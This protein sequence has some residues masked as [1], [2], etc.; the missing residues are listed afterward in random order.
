MKGTR[1]T[2]WLCTLLL[3]LSLTH[4]TANAQC[5]LDDWIALKAL[6]ESTDGDN[7]TDNTNWQEVTGNQPTGNCNLGN[8]FG[9]Q[10][11]ENGRVS[12]LD[13]DGVDDCLINY[14]N[15]GN[16]LNGSI[17]PE[18][19]R[20]SGLTHLLLQKNELSGSIP[21]EM[22]ELS[23]LTNLYLSD[24]QLTGSI[25]PELGELSNLAALRLNF[26]K[27]SG[28]IPPELGKLTNL[29]SLYLSGNE[30]SG[31]IPPELGELI[32]LKGMW[33]NQNKLSGSIPPALGKLNKLIW[34]M[35]YMN[36]LSGSI[37]PELGDLS[38]LHELGLFRNQL[39]GSIPPE[40]STLSKLTKLTLYANQLN[41]SIP[42]ELGNL[43]NLDWLEIN[44]NNLSGCYDANL[45]KLCTQ[46]SNPDFKGNADISDG[47][48]FDAT[49][50]DFCAK[51]VDACIPPVTNCHID[52]WT[53]LKALYE[54][55]DGINW[56]N[57]TN[58][59]EVTGNQ[60]TNNCNLE[61]LYGVRLDEN[62]RVSCLDFDGVDDCIIDYGDGG[63]NLNGSIPPEVGRLSNLTRLLLHNNNLSGNIPFELG[64]LSNLILLNLSRNKLNGSI[65]VELEKLSNLTL[66]H[67]FTNQLSDN[68]PPELGNLSNLTS[69]W[70][71][72]NQLS[73]NIPPTLSRLNKLEY[74]VL[75]NNQ[76]IGD[77]PYELGELSNLLAL[78]LSGNQLSGS[79]PP[80]LS[81][82]SKLISLLLAFNELNGT[83]PVELA[84]LTELK[85]LELHVNQLSGN[86]PIELTNLSNLE[87]LS[88]S[89]NQLSGSIPPALSKLSNLQY[90]GLRENEFSGS[91]PPELGNLSNLQYLGLS[92]N[93]IIGNMPTELSN[94]INL[95]WLEINNNNLSGCYDA[96]L[97]ILCTQLN[98]TNFKGNADISDGNNFDATWEDFCTTDAGVCIPPI[99]N[100][101]ID[102]WT[103]LKALY[104]STNGINWTNNTNWQEVT[105]NQPTNNCNLETLYGV[106][107]DENG[108]VSCLDFDGVDDCIIDYG[109]GGNNLNGSIP[110]EVGRLNNLTRLLLQNN[111]LSGSIPPELGNLSN[112][113]WLILAINELNGSIPA[114]LGNLN[115]LT[116]LHIFTNQLSGR[117]PPELGNL[118]NLSSLWLADNQLIGEIPTELGEL[119]NLLALGFSGNQFSGNIPTELG[120]LS[121]LEFLSA[122]HNNLSGCYDAD[123][124][125][126]CTQLNNPDFE[127][128]EDISD[129][130]NFDATWEDFCA[131]GVDACIKY[132]HIDDWTALKAIYL[133]TNNAANWTNRDNWDIFKNENP[134]QDCNLSGLHG[135]SF[136]DEGRVDSINLS[137]NNL[138]GNLSDELGEANFSVIDISHNYFSF[139]EVA[140][141]KPTNKFKYSPQYFGEIE[142]YNQTERDTVTIST[143]YPYLNQLS[144]P[145]YKWKKDGILI[146]EIDTIFSIDDAMQND[147]GAYRLHI[148]ESN[149]DIELELISE[150]IHLL[151]KGFDPIGAPVKPNEFLYDFDNQEA[152][153]AFKEEYEQITFVDSCHCDSRL[154]YLIRHESDSIAAT[155]MLDILQKT[156]TIVDTT[157]IE[158]S[159]HI[160]E[161]G[162][163]TDRGPV[164]KYRYPPLPN[165]QNSVSI[166]LLDTGFDFGMTI[167][168]A[169]FGTPNNQLCPAISQQDFVTKIDDING[170][171]SNGFRFITDGLD[172]SSQIKVTPLRV[173]E[174]RQTSLFK[175]ICALYYSIDQGADIINLS[176]GYSGLRS[177]ILEDALSYA[178]EKG[179]FIVT[180]AGNDGV[181]IDLK[182]HYPATFSGGYKNVISIG[183]IN[184]NNRLTEFTNYGD[185]A[186]TLVAQGK[187]MIGFGMDD[188]DIIGNGTSY[189]TYFVARMLA[190][191]IAEDNTLSSEEVWS[192][193]DTKYLIDNPETIG[194]CSTG[195][196]LDIEVIEI[197]DSTC[198]TPQTIE[199]NSIEA[200]KASIAW[201]DF[202][203]SISYTLK[204][205]EKDSLYWELEMEE[206]NTNKY[207]LT[208]L[209][210]CTT[211]EVIVQS[212]CMHN[213][214]SGYSQIQSF[215]TKNCTHSPPPSPPLCP[216][217][218]YIAANKVQSKSA[219]IEWHKYSKCG[220]TGYNFEYRK[221]GG[222]WICKET[223]G[224]VYQLNNLEKC[225]TYQARVNMICA[226]EKSGYS[227][228]IE[229]T[230]LD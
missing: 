109:S 209:K 103:A 23:N 82:L 32:N 3:M 148:T 16:N 92:K 228:T 214:N 143:S 50:E 162:V 130:N 187:N 115:N 218:V 83:I 189:S 200:N 139:Q 182:P 120:N 150:P 66:L 80:E 123:L 195:K 106:R 85:N 202:S 2:I 225:T 208:N 14:G 155:V 112:L 146:N 117:I 216:T 58:W 56:T 105:G 210:D 151:V 177:K 178:Q 84:D 89:I 65:P 27:L 203:S 26:N 207:E 219:E 107:L 124:A 229:F 175:L 136:D 52:D 20:L 40:L 129:G 213:T 30:L 95:D 180:A 38:N 87:K 174:D 100:C 171:G 68:I 137:R 221:V 127:G 161:S 145:T 188:K 98:N 86:I 114:E 134:P 33:L 128:N 5:H 164:F 74:L 36:E 169:H 17:P 78:G 198:F 9:V 110:P 54:S 125:K 10:L 152:L 138:S 160:V 12:C 183:S 172:A 154:L 190:L 147:V 144:E 75:H 44:H 24:N 194:M 73:G 7:W 118:S 18:L 230:T 163:I 193:F 4:L 91:I 1:T 70:L 158:D 57:N 133:S 166:Y 205:R 69:L 11:D 77:I 53:A 192:K 97:T 49:W 185:T 39:S 93:K 131:K 37:P 179:I 159:N 22:G 220:Q 55:T 48:N 215:T 181:D 211:Y 184:H 99:T 199:I 81:K 15:D 6:Y 222:E 135:V 167:N 141:A 204:I 186:V 43:N 113:I 90:L 104:E 60:P 31:S 45:A 35:L 41:G 79:I 153:E 201:D 34:L 217:P 46:L 142:W 206:I 108:R 94:L 157:F 64:N 191:V 122:N 156:E 111:N 72:G 13:L 19:G 21:P 119:R 88:L 227:P 25:P 176:A 62:G 8:L 197:S 101:H 47:N 173:F 223:I 63:N 116:W 71:E 29:E 121:K 224:V 59:Q 196:R 51:G 42:P 132:C 126:L 28:S 67:M 102:D 149:A 212:N 76:L 61:T 96:N 140:N 168:T 165:I 226:D 170:H